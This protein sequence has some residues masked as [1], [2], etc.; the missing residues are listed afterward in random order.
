MTRTLLV[1][2]HQ[3]VVGKFPLRILVEVLHVRMRWCIVEVKVI[4]LH[5]L[6]VITLTV[7]QSEQPFFE[8]G[9]LAIP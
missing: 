7:R 1:R 4:L 3:I 9:I 5:I 2:G 8:D 6:P